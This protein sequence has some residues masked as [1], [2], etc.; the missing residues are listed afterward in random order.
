[1][2]WDLAGELVEVLRRPKFAAYE[3]DEADVA[4][5]VALVDPLLP[6]VTVAVALQDPAD[7]IVIEAATAAEVDAIVTGDAD[8]LDDADL[9]DW[10]AA[11]GIDV[12]TPAEVVATLG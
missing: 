3:F 2:S 1:M 6:K 7:G 10:L 4:D 12:L 11:R 9:L 5:L 8:I